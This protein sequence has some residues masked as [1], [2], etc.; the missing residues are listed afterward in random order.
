MNT[1]GTQGRVAGKTAVVTGGG[2]GIGRACAEV[3]AAEG[4]RVVITQRHEESAAQT[5]D[6]VRDRGGEIRFVAQDVTVEDDWKRL[7]DETGE[8]YGPP[9][10]LVNNAGVYLIKPLAEC[11]VEDWRK[12]MDVNALGC[13]LGLKHVAPAMAEQN[14][15]S[16]VNM[17]SV[18]GL[19]GVSGHAVYG[20]SKGAVTTLTKDAAIEYAASNVRVN[21]VH[22]GYIDTA[23][24]DYGAEKQDATKEDLGRMFPMNRIGTPEEV[25]W[26]V[27]YL[28]SDEAGFVTG[29]Q[30]VIDGGFTAG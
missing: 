22:P 21:S 3:L 18:A 4:A 26:G 9:D 14:K 10:I 6:K 19:A 5:V 1:T 13:F 20:S 27:L 29:A 8:A 12:I 25:A 16:I 15:G 30:L 28:A 2:K 7:L 11:T 24:A 23:M 17:S